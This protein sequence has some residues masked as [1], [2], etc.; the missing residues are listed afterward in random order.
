[1][2]ERCFSRCQKNPLLNIFKVPVDNNSTLHL[3]PFELSKV[4]KNKD[5]DAEHA[6][7]IKNSKMTR[8]MLPEGESSRTNKKEHN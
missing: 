2:Y 6:S 1:M 8:V 4:L 7:T 3:L 5:N